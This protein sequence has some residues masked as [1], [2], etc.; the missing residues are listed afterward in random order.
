MKEEQLKKIKIKNHK[1]SYLP[2]GNEETR[3]VQMTRQETPGDQ[4]HKLIEGWNF[5]GR[6]ITIE[7]NMCIWV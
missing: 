2:I 5:F 6:G 4:T 3:F 1:N 7:P